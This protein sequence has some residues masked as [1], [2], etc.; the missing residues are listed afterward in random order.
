MA[1]TKRTMVESVGYTM[2]RHQSSK[3]GIGGRIRE[4]A[5]AHRRRF[6]VLLIGGATLVCLVA[7]YVLFS[8]MSWQSFDMRTD[9]TRQTTQASIAR[10]ERTPQQVKEIAKVAKEA[11]VTIEQMCDFSPLI[12]WQTNIF[13]VVNKAVGKCQTQQEKLQG[14]QV[15]LKEIHT[16]IQSEQE[17]ASILN[18]A[19]QALGALDAA[20]FEARHGQWQNTLSSLEELEMHKSLDSTRTAARTAV[21]EIIGAYEALAAAHAAEDRK[22]FDEATATHAKGYSKLGAIQNHSVDSYDKLVNTLSKEL[23]DS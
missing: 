17:F 3:T 4:Y 20:D 1:A 7:A 23:R 18:D 6:I 9:K 12:Q 19:Q 2:R 14:S 11:R 8:V 5:G 21:E 15:A 22:A 10:L 16:R 13:S